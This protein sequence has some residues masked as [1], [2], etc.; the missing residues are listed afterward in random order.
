[1]TLRQAMA[2]A[3]AMAVM[4]GSVPSTLMAQQT[5]TLAGTANKEAKKP[6]T[7]YTVQA[8][9]VNQGT[10]A[11]M[12]ALDTDA[13]FALPPLTPS[14]YLVELLN[15]D[16]KV[17]CTEGPYDVSKAPMAKT[18]VNID[19]GHKALAW[20]LIGLAGAAAITAAVVT[21]PAASGAQ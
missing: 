8:R 14:R 2:T 11:G 4:G 21:G 16:G 6:Y 17:I 9:D 13:K 10:I 3:V 18:D 20:W 1:M 5:A 12:I 7:D 15:K 19:C